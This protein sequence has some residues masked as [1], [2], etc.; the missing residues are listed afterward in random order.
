MKVF[1]HSGL[2]DELADMLA[3]FLAAAADLLLELSWECEARGDWVWE[4][5]NILANLNGLHEISSAGC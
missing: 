1:L 2:P 5:L 3:D 4:D